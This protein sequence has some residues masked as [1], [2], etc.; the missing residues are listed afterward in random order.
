MKYKIHSYQ[1]PLD[2]KIE[3][4]SLDEAMTLLLSYHPI[5]KESK[6]LIVIVEWK[7]GQKQLFLANGKIV[8]FDY[9][10]DAEARRKELLE[11]E[12]KKLIAYK[13][14]LSQLIFNLEIAVK[15]STKYLDIP[16]INQIEDLFSEIIKIPVNELKSEEKEIIGLLP[17][18]DGRSDY[19]SE[20]YRQKLLD[21]I[22]H[23]NEILGNLT[24]NASNGSS[25]NN[26]NKVVGA[27]ALLL[28]SQGRRIEESLDTISD[29]FGFEG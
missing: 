12:A 11:I 6:K 1:F 14:E 15:N 29:G 28:A 9:K 5:A 17:K 8:D 26:T 19:T 22:S 25:S 27:A 10:E 16:D 4:E 3:A 21:L 23:Q 2:E 24:G 7:K 13:K 20:K 18:V